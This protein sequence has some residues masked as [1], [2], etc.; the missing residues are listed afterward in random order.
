MPSEYSMLRRLLRQ[1]QARPA[2]VVAPTRDATARTFWEL[3]WWEKGLDVISRPLYTVAGAAHALAKGGNPFMG[4]AKGFAGI[5]RKTF[6]D[7]L[8]VVG[9]RDDVARGLMGFAMDV[10]ADPLT[11][12]GI[13]PVGAA[14]RLTLK[15]VPTALSK[16]GQAERVAISGARQARVAKALA[17]T[18]LLKPRVT[19]APL[20]ERQAAMA[21]RLIER[22]R[23]HAPSE[24]G[25]LRSIPQEAQ[26]GLVPKVL[27]EARAKQIMAARIPKEPGLAAPTA[28]KWAGMPLVTAKTLK[29][30]T[31]PIGRAYQAAKGMKV[32]GPVLRRAEQAGAA[33]KGAVR[34]VF[35][36]EIENKE[37]RAVF[38]ATRD[39]LHVERSEALDAYR[40]LREKLGTYFKGDQEKIDYAFREIA[41][42]LEGIEVEVMKLEPS[43]RELVLRRRI[44]ELGPKLERLAEE[45]RPV[46]VYE[47]PTEL[48]RELQERIS[49]L[50][51]AKEELIRAGSVSPKAKAEIAAIET[52]I[53]EYQG[54]LEQAGRMEGPVQEKALAKTF[55]EAEQ[56]KI[57]AK[58]LPHAEKVAKMRA[59]EARQ[60]SAE[61]S[62]Y[63]VQGIGVTQEMLDEARR[64]LQEKAFAKQ[65]Q[66][67]AG[68]V[69]KDI[70]LLQKKIATVNKRE[71]IIAIEAE[72]GQ[73][74]QHLKQSWE[75]V[76]VYN[77]AAQRQYH[78]A[79]RRLDE[80]K[81]ALAKTEPMKVLYRERQAYTPKEPV[82][83]EVAETVRGRM[84]KVLGREQR[85]ATL[86]P[87]RRQFYLPHYFD[88]SIEKSLIGIVSQDAAKV[89]RSEFNG[90]LSNALRRT[91]TGDVTE[92]TIADLVE[93]GSLDVKKVKAELERRGVAMTGFDELVFEQN[94]LAAALRREL[95]SINVVTAAE[96]M[97]D[98]LSSPSFVKSSGN[99]ASVLEGYRKSKHLP[100][101]AIKSDPDFQAYKRMYAMLQ[102]HEDHSLFIP[103]RDYIRIFKTAAAKE[104]MR[105]G[106][107]AELTR[108]MVVDMREAFRGIGGLDEILEKTGLD[109]AAE[110]PVAELYVIPRDVAEHVSK[111]YQLGQT[112]EALKVF[113]HDYFDKFQS[114]WK[115]FATAPRPAF[116]V[117]NALS[118]LWQMYLAGVSPQAT[119]R[120]LTLT[121][122][123]LRK[124]I[125]PVAGYS[126]EQIYELSRR[127]GVVKTG[128]IGQDVGE[129][130][131]RAVA[132]SKAPWSARG[133]VARVGMAVGT[134]IE[135]A[136][137][138]ATF[139]DGLEKGMDP[140]AAAMRVKKYL[141]DYG[142]LTSVEKGLFR[143]V[144]PFYTWTRKSIPLA[145]ET[146]I[147]QPG[148]VAILPK[149]RE[150]AERTLDA[151]E[152]EYLAEYIQQ[153]FGIPVRKDAATGEVSYLLLKG[154]IPTADLAKID[155]REL[156][157][158]LSP[159]IK[160]PLEQVFNTDFYRMKP[161]SRFP[162][163]TVEFMGV[164]MPVRAAHVL[165][166]VVIMA[167]I[168]REVFREGATAG[169][170]LA[171]EAG[172]RLQA[173]RPVDIMRRYVLG[174]QFEMGE[175]KRQAERARASG[176]D[177]VAAG[178][179]Q[180]LALLMQRRDRARIGAKEIDPNAF[181]TRKPGLTPKKPKP[182]LRLDQIQ[183]QMR[184]RL[185]PT[186]TQP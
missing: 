159:L 161:V 146:A 137:R 92:V 11:Y 1:T 174:L 123:D 98:I 152:R 178:L 9:F 168:D 176:Q 25:L 145:L 171:S 48:T 138:L 97:H 59:A 102:Q 66:V 122:Q 148:K 124:G 169:K 105:L 45:A 109:K 170:A 52:K 2:P 57:E 71:D 7:V 163:E 78:G 17:P 185:R 60:A 61:A 173:Q 82:L 69:A 14:G 21:Q 126:G 136:A 140:V 177:T 12:V 111:A 37:L 101:E 73:L 135:D 62:A 99:L 143:R 87:E 46:R 139:I 23:G 36:P 116:H 16:I 113:V 112:P 54:H 90:K 89:L 65:M 79:L 130:L 182:L 158:M 38:T 165:R 22:A 117:R 179:E 147:T 108:S 156:L 88:K 121:F 181:R 153:N 162:T 128:F 67:A 118:N 84:E 43:K 132:P 53:K 149:A 110:V 157:G 104:Q 172:L 94:P 47:A 85:L 24:V 93:R 50:H 83:R 186:G 63:G 81:A 44:G 150:E 68:T 134:K 120:A 167:Q 19:A 10:V 166:N 31:E 183:R 28:L 58:T 56:A 18:A 29:P 70:K 35:G 5:E 15:G 41:K 8:K 160:T 33:L 154:Y 49:N 107:E 77:D 103:S 131:E 86:P 115:V 142:D 125:A 175:M 80:L 141:F 40:N 6:S 42:A 133:P 64:A 55:S 3:P 96:M 155:A 27:G 30:I 74:E 127:L 39:I 164:P 184:A 76:P 144:A 26:A 180:R 4:A 129:A 34:T 95:T 106:A 51:M 91:H 20:A 32:I 114:W 75:R 72:I 100:A 119:L 13:G 151:P